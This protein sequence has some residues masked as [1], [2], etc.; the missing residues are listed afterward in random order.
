[1][2]SLP[3]FR[4]KAS[5]NLSLVYG[6]LWQ[7]F[8]DLSHFWHLEQCQFSFFILIKFL[9]KPGDYS[10]VLKGF[11]IDAEGLGLNSQAGRVG[12][13][14]ANGSLPLRRFFGAAL[15]RR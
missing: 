1:M 6:C 15:P 9:K 2:P 3:S 8:Y 4:P 13:S 12:H 11:A 14:V 5:S 7:Y 10:V